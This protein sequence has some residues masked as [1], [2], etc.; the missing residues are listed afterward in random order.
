VWTIGVGH[1]G[2]EV[3]EGQT[4]TQEQA[5]AL[6]A[7]DVAWAEN[8]VK[9]LVTVK[10]MQDQFDALVDFV[11]NLGETAFAGSTLLKKLNAGDYLSASYEFSRWNKAGGKVLAGLVTRRAAEVQ[12]FVS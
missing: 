5:D 3:H 6:L 10:L 9:R 1:T 11:F 8:A 4:V 2:P 12:V 7:S